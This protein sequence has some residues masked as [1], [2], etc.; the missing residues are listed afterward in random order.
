[1]SQNAKMAASAEQSFSI[2]P[3]EKRIFLKTEAKK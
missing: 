2:G 3:Y 1:V